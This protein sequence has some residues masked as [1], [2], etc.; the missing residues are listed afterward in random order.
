MPKITR[1]SL[2]DSK[3]EDLKTKLDEALARRNELA[4]LKDDDLT[5]EKLIELEDAAADVT[6]I[7]EETEA[8]EVAAQERT[9]RIAAARE[10]AKDA[11]ADKDKPTEGDKDSSEDGGEDGDGKD[12]QEIVVPDDASEL[13]ESQETVTA[14][15]KGVAAAKRTAPTVVIPVEEPEAPARSVITAAA[16]VPQFEQGQE[17]ETLLDTASAFMSRSKG[18]TGGRGPAKPNVINPGVF[19]LSQGHQR[20]GVA[21]IAKP[22]AEFVTGMNE[23]ADKQLEVIFAAAKESRLPQGSLVAAGGWCAPSENIYDGFLE[24]ETVSGIL[25][26]PEVQANRGGINFT[27]G[28]DYGSIASSFGF[29]QTEAQA[30]AGTE[31]VCY[32]VECPPFQEVRLDAVGFCITA[33]V[34][35][36]ATYPELVRR[37]LAIGA[38]AHQ[39][40][41]NARVIS[42]IS[43]LIGTAVNHAELGSATA[44]LLDALSLQATRIRYTYSMAPNATIEAVLPVWAKEIVKSDLSRRSGVDLLNVSDAQVNAYLG[45]RGIAAQWVYDYQNLATANTGTWTSW[46][47]TLEVLMYPAGAFVK[48]TTDVIDLD[49]IYDSVGLSTNTYTAAFFEEGVAVA[50]T[51]ASGVKVAIDV[52]DLY[53][54][55]GALELSPTEAGA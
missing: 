45:A 4:A 19:G 9:D 1:E 35:T 54:R 6:T 34:L 49:T 48:L 47:D 55:G 16:N 13:V 30:E 3:A 42:D 29:T 7:R 37:V 21:R 41:V 28:P 46:P 15:A 23:P 11:E 26:I 14:S 31:K 50:N 22:E 5:D 53:G 32:E 2:A 10:S 39:H 51:G 24:L 12:E 40:K 27:K 44:D 38:V 25:S 17:L 36:N 8:R 18:F 33:G 52:T 43:T 20:Y